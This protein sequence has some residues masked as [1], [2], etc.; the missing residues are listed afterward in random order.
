LGESEGVQLDDA[1]QIMDY[2]DKNGIESIQPVGFGMITSI[3]NRKKEKSLSTL[4]QQ[5]GKKQTV[6]SFIKEYPRL[7][8]MAQ[9]SFGKRT[10]LS[11]KSS[12]IDQLK[13]DSTQGIL[14]SVKLS[15]NLAPYL[16]ISIRLHLT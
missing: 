9:L 6:G 7:S 16:H 2:V 14:A 8:S 12:E 5:L 10:G 4:S 1:Y 11:L 3:G 15:Q 13:S